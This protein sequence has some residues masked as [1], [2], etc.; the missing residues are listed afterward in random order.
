MKVQPSHFDPGLSPRGYTGRTHPKALGT[1]CLTKA[2]R[3]SRT[4]ILHLFGTRKRAWLPVSYANGR[5]V[6]RW[7][8]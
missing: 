4:V 2:D 6:V 8:G 7:A 3:A 5:H 1:I